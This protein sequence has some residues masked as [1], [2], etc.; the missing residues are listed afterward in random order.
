[1]LS[2]KKTQN[3][4]YLFPGQKFLNI[5]WIAGL[6]YLLKNVQYGK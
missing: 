6:S 1:M 4:G 5:M 2:K 3:I